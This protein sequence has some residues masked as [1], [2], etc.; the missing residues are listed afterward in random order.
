LLLKKPEEELLFDFGGCPQ[1][2]PTS[3]IKAKKVRNL[4]IMVASTP[5]NRKGSHN[6]YIH[7]P[8]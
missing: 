2:H 7:F 5:F 6:E 1:Q 4:Y 8:S 3:K